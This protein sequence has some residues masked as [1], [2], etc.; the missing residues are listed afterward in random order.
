MGNF[1]RSIRLISFLLGLLLGLVFMRPAAF[2]EAAVPVNYQTTLVKSKKQKTARTR[3]SRRAK[4][5][6][7]SAV[8]PAPRASFDRVLSENRGLLNE[9][10]DAEL[11]GT[12]IEE[13]T[14]RAHVKFLA[15]DLLEG[16]SPSGRGGMLAAKY[17]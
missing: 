8:T 4:T 5:R 11:A 2:L 16:R 10:N 9:A 13:S 12:K 15:D 7:R 17:I 6:V 3:R 1:Y 14:I